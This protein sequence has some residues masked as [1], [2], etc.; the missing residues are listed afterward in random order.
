MKTKTK[1]PLEKQLRS[2]VRRWRKD[3]R[4]YKQS[5]KDH[6]AENHKETA[7]FHKGIALSYN[8]CAE[9]LKTLLKN[10]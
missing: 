4:L 2:L 8:R 6:L 9:E 1:P 3:H 5:V 7:H 10:L